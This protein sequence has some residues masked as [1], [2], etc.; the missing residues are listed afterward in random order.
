MLQKLKEINSIINDFVWVK[1]G[2]IILIGTGILMTVLKKNFCADDYERCADDFQHCM[3][4]L[5]YIKRFDDASKPGW[6]HS[7]ISGYTEGAGGKASKAKIN[8]WE[9]K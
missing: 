2:L 6:H 1:T 8:V 3:G 4:Y 5:R 7:R 9:N